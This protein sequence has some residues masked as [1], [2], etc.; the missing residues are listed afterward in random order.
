M[1]DTPIARI[2]RFNRAVTREAGVLDQSYLGRGRPLGPARVLYAVG[3]EGA[4]LDDIRSYLGLNDPMLSRYLNALQSEGLLKLDREQS[5]GRRHAHLTKAGHIELTAY[6]TLSDTQAQSLLD[7][8]PR[9]Q[10][11]LEAMDLIA[12][13]LGQ[14]DLTF[15]E[16]DPRSPDAL[17]CLEAYYAELGARLNTGFDVALSADPEA[18]D[19]M[20]PR[21]SFVVAMSDGF[22]LG[23]VGVKGTDKGYGEIKRLWVSPAARGM[24]LAKRLMTA[25]EASARALGIPM[26]RLDTNSALPEA[27]KLYQTTGWS[28]IAR[29]ND[30]PYPDVFFEKAL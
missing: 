4:D 24:G 19:M 1:S 13:A 18:G 12:S 6:N 9:P 23:C 21:G 11:L 2:R 29:F 5:D 8:H 22:P 25:A 26:L 28:E 10:A 15:V 3:S 17:Y 20:A 30:D 7:R 14:S 16:I 27:V